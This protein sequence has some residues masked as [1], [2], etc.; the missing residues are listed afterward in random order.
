MDLAAAVMDR[1]CR[2]ASSRA[3]FPGPTEIV[4]PDMTRMRNRIDGACRATPSRLGFDERFPGVLAFIAR[5]SIDSTI[6]P[7]ATLHHRLGR[8]IEPRRRGDGY[9]RR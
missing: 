9:K 3:I 6:L 4:S 8:E 2:I 7:S 1:V 5:H